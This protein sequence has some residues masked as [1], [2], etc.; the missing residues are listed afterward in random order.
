MCMFFLLYIFECWWVYKIDVN[1]GPSLN[2]IIIENVKLWGYWSAYYS[3]NWINLH[4]SIVFS[5]YF[6]YVVVVV[7]N[8][9]F[10]IDSLWFVLST[11]KKFFFFFTPSN[12]IISTVRRRTKTEYT[13]NWV[14]TTFQ[15]DLVQIWTFIL[16]VYEIK[17]IKHWY[18][19]CCRQTNKILIIYAEI[20]FILISLEHETDFFFITNNQK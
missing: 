5:W 6:L 12:K 4:R 11:K 13:L 9:H 18:Y 2:G 3:L 17:C 7:A 10:R 15:I 14:S 16:F 20:P 19:T 1:Y 8:S